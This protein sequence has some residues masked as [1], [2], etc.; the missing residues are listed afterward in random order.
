[1]KGDIPVL[2]ALDK[3][4]HLE[5]LEDIVSRYRMAISPMLNAAIDDE[6]QF[7]LVQSMMITAAATHAGLTV[8]HMIAVG[9]MT[10]QDKRRAGQVVLTAFRSAIEAG[11][12]EARAAMLQ[13]MPT[14]GQA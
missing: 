4:E 6:D 12:R 14:Q 5:L 9:G 3:P 1:M 10:D 2:N 8:G 11:K 7:K 13:Q